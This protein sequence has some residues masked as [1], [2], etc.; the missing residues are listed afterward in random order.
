LLSAKADARLALVLLLRSTSNKLVD[1]QNP[2]SSRG[3]CYASKMEK[4]PRP[5]ARRLQRGAGSGSRGCTQDIHR[6]DF[7]CSITGQADVLVV[8]EGIHADCSLQL[9]PKESLLRS[10]RLAVEI[11]LDV[12]VMMYV[13]MIG[14]DLNCVL[15]RVSRRTCSLD[16]VHSSTFLLGEDEWLLYYSL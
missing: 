9:A 11:G 8:Q 3:F 13:D 5:E 16:L 6:P 12:E 15:D 10:S 7:S 1:T 4:T 2:L 14:E